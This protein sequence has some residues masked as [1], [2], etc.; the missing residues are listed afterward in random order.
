[1]AEETVK[2][3]T[4]TKLMFYA[5]SEA[6]SISMQS[7]FDGSP[8]EISTDVPNNHIADISSSNIQQSSPATTMVSP[9]KSART[10]SLS[11]VARL[12]HLQKRI[13]GSSSSCD[14]SEKGDQ[15]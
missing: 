2:R 8:S 15:Q 7:S 3:I 5:M 1:M 10:A 9:N 12:E 4:G 13:R 11:R 14:P 6:S